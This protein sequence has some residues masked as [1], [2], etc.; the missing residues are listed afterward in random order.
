MDGMRQQ[1]AL[2]G[3]SGV[4]MRIMTTNNN[5]RQENQARTILLAA[6]DESAVGILTVD[7]STD[8]LCD[9]INTVIDTTDI[10]VVSFDFD[11]EACSEK[12]ILTSQMDEDIASLVLDNA[13]SMDGK[14]INVGYVNDINFAP[15]RKRNDVWEAYKTAFNWNQVFFVEN[16]TEFATQGELQS[17]IADPIKVSAVK[18]TVDTIDVYGADIND[19]DIAAMRSS[20]WKATAGGDPRYIGGALTRMVAKSAAKELMEKQLSIPS[21]LVTQ[22]FLLENNVTSLRD[23][24]VALPA[25]GLP[26]F[27]SA[28]WIKTI[29]GD[30]DV[31]VPTPTPTTE[32]PT[33]EAPS[34]GNM[35]SWLTVPVCVTF[36]VLHYVMLG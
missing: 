30:D 35:V 33:T 23:L 28:C 8:T 9:A 6:L 7:G 29:G 36:G 13:V 25:M 26:D 27:V 11:G 4:N 10:A 21:T 5:N 32:A 22:D 19:I 14:G 15:L 31:P 17:A 1:A 12:H 24:D 18:E 20:T 3:E 34:S 2:V 16:A